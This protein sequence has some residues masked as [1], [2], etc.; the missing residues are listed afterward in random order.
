[1]RFGMQDD[2]GGGAGV[3]ACVVVAEIQ[4][5]DFLEVPQ[6]MPAIAFQ[7]GPCSA[8]DGHAVDPAEI[9]CIPPVGAAGGIHG[10]FVEIAMLNQMMAGQDWKKKVNHFIKSRGIP[11]MLRANP[12]NFDTTERDLSGFC[13]LTVEVS[14]C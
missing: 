11:D 12:P 13:W 4:L 6:T 10:L 3:F 8:G 9:R 14:M 7:L 1:M 5:Q 2:L